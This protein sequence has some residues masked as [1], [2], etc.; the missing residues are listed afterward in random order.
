MP[1]FLAAFD[2]LGKRVV[3]D[4]LFELTGDMEA[5]NAAIKA[6]VD[7]KWTGIHPEKQ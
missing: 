3:L 2:D 6:Y 4:R 1:V 7:T 5:D